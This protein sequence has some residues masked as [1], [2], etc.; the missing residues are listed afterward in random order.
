MIDER[1]GRS[2]W[3][4]PACR[5]PQEGARHPG[6]R[7]GRPHRAPRLPDGVAGQQCGRTA[8][9]R[10]VM[11]RNSI[12]TQHRPERRRHLD[13]PPRPPRSPAS[14]SLTS[15]HRILRRMRPQ[16]RETAPPARP[17]NGSCR[18]TPAPKTSAPGHSRPRPGKPARI[19]LPSPASPETATPATGIPP[20]G[21]SEY[22]LVAITVTAPAMKGNPTSVRKADPA[23]DARRRRNAGATRPVSR[24]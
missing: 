9:P 8:D 3:P 15:A 19:T 13:R 12:Q 2:R 6:P 7:V 5:N 22:L 24:A 4:P 1:R 10:P 17:W 18:G 14:T 23:A 11:T 20:H 16:R 21:T